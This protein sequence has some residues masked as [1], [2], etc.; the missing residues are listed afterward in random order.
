MQLFFESHTFLAGHDAWEPR[1]STLALSVF[2]PGSP[3]AVWFES[4]VDHLHCYDAFVTEFRAY[5]ES[6]SADLLSL[7][8]RWY[9]ARQAG[10]VTQIYTYLQR[11]KTRS[12]HK[13]T[14]SLKHNPFM[15]SWLG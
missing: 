10:S 8:E 7:R 11:S 4:I 3:T 6:R 13:V 5:F 1:R 14:R 9:R 2:P 15:R 12:L